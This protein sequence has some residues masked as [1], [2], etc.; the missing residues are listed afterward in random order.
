MLE[1]CLLKKQ[2]KLTDWSIVKF[3]EI[4]EWLGELPDEVY[5]KFDGSREVCLLGRALG[6]SR[7]NST[8]KSFSD[9]RRIRTSPIVRVQE[10]V[11]ETA[12]TMYLLDESDMSDEYRKWLELN[13]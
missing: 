4:R 6:D 13:K 12:N 10:G 2:A 11:Y 1:V 5:A 9:G 8:T 7:Y 3:P